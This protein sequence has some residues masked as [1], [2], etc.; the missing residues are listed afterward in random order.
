M[1]SLQQSAGTSHAKFWAWFVANEASLFNFE[2]D[3]DRIFS[4]LAAALATVHPDLVFEFGPVRDGKRE[5][6]I[7]AGGLQAVF[8][9]VEALAAAAPELPRWRV[10]KFR[11]RRAYSGTLSLGGVS[12]STDQIFFSADPDD[13][14]L[15]LTLYIDGYARTPN[16][17]YEHIGYLLLDSALGEYD[18]ETKIGF[19]RFAPTPL[20]GTREL[21]PLDELARLVD[22][23]SVN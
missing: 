3:Q 18:V 6:V 12:V 11:P 20:D 10:T 22:G 9:A 17:V 16:S 21:R 13:G 2:Q 1:T 5:F 14:K 19:I 23:S 7:S 8:P 4:N 15:G